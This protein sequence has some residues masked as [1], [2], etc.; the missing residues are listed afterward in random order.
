MHP[1]MSRFDEFAAAAAVRL[2][3]SAAGIASEQNDDGGDAA[4]EV[5]QPGLHW[6]AHKGE[7]TTDPRPEQLRAGD[8]WS[9]R[10]AESNGSAHP[11][12][13]LPPPTATQSLNCASQ[14]IQCKF[15]CP[16]R[17]KSVFCACLAAVAF[18]DSRP[19]IAC[20]PSD[21]TLALRSHTLMGSLPV[22]KSFRYS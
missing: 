15:T 5:R 10:Q 11:E 6:H 20:L 16:K 2:V 21:Q 1:S 7:H 14:L 3:R 13:G 12:L 8:V 22:S 9:P 4:I 17:V 19:A 18:H